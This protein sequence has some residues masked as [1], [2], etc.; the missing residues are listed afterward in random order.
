MTARM[1]CIGV[2][3]ITEQRSPRTRI[4]VQFLAFEKDVS[5]SRYLRIASALITLWE[6]VVQKLQ[7]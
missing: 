5:D 7:L 2:S 1:L 3:F 6:E 4:G